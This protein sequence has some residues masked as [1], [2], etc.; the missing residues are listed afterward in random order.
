MYII[1]DQK[2]LLNISFYVNIYIS[3]IYYTYIIYDILYI[4]FRYIIDKVYNMTLR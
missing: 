2:V 4:Y 3:D 1:Q